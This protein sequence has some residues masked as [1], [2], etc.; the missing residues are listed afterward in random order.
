MSNL[1]TFFEK[2]WQKNFFSQPLD[3]F[4]DLPYTFYIMETFVFIGNCKYSHYEAYGYILS[5][6]SDFFTEKFFSQPLDFFRDLPYTFYIMEI[7]VF[8]GN[9]KYSHYEAYGYILSEKRA[10]SHKKNRQNR[11]KYLIQT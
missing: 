9:C 8:I 6:K 10:F 7:F 11:T 3:F 4:R 2:D 5:E 1:A